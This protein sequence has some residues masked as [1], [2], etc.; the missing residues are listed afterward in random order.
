MLSGRAVATLGVDGDRDGFLPHEDCDDADPFVYPGAP[1]ICDAKDDDCDGT[2]P[3]DESDFDGDGA[4]LCGGDCADDDPSVS[5]LLFESC[6]GVDDDCDGASGDGEADADGDGHRPCDDDCDDNEP[7]VHGGAADDCWDLLDNDCDG[8]VNGGCDCPIF[9][10]TEAPDFCS[11]P[12]TYACPIGSVQ[13]AVDV[14]DQRNCS[15][16][17][18]EPGTYEERLVIEYADLLL[19]PRPDTSGLVAIDAL[20]KGRVVDVE[21]GAVVQIAEIGITGG[22][23]ADGGGIRVMGATLTLDAVQIVGNACTPG[24]RGGGLFAEDSS[25]DVVGSLFVDNQCGWSLGDGGNDGGAAYLLGGTVSISDSTFASNL[26]GDG[27]AIWSGSAVQHTFLRD[28][29]RDNDS[30]D[31]GGGLGEFDGGT[32]V[33]DGDHKDL[34]NCVFVGNEASA[35]AGA[36]AVLGAAGSTTIANNVFVGNSAPGG[37]GIHFGGSLWSYF[38]LEK[39]G[40]AHV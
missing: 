31:S 13:D 17:Y 18:L 21:P 39:I 35:G 11:P 8:I 27:S 29:F 38:V 4:T 23:V 16:V 32:L 14:A 30:G 37:A 10:A 3:L 26:A 24:G 19:R 33:L 15:I 40:R 12:G 9:A 1:E 25:V 20:G 34:R 22:E 5:P 28:E 2:L 36:L 7:E 6:N